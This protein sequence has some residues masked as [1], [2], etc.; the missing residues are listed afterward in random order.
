[1][2][3]KEPSLYLVI[4]EEYGIDRSAVEIAKAAIAGGVDIIQMREKN[5]LKPELIE[6][7]KKLAKICKDNSV[8]FI[9]NDD[10]KIAKETGADGVHLG[11]DDME[12]CPISEARKILGRD[13]IIGV[14]THS[15][16]TFK[17]ACSE[18]VDYIAYGPVFPTEIKDNCVGMEDIAR[19]MAM[20]DKPVFFIG[21]INL[22][23]VDRLIEKGA[24]NVSLIRD[25][26]RSADITA[27]TKA[28]KHRISKKE[29][30]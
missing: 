5:K 12:R 7:G 18:D 29:R 16:E 17:K 14:S 1:M 24:K 11:Q 9:V 26:L 30:R 10:P 20:T 6:L 4:T 2:A 15:I 28:I 22:N 21:G 27:R 3:I 8:L 19:I 13:K 25:I 23:N